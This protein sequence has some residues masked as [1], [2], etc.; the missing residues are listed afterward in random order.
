[1]RSDIGKIAI[2]L[3]SFE[4]KAKS[5]LNIAKYSE[6]GLI[7]NFEDDHHFLVPQLLDN[8]QIV[9]KILGNDYES[10]I[11]SYFELTPNSTFDD[12]KNSVLKEII[13]R[14][15]KIPSF[16]KL[17]DIMNWLDKKNYKV[18][19]FILRIDL[20]FNNNSLYKI[21]DFFRIYKISFIGFSHINLASRQFKQFKSICSALFQNIIYEKLYDYKDIEAF[22]N[23]LEEL[24]RIKLP[25]LLKKEIFK[26]CGGNLWLVKQ[27]VRYFRN[28]PNSGIHEVLSHNELLEKAALV[29]ER[30][31]PDEKRTAIKILNEEPLTDDE[32][33]N[34]EYL[35]KIG[36]FIEKDREY[37][38]AI[39]LLSKV[40]DIKP[41]TH[42]VNLRND[43]IYL[44]N[45]IISDELTQ[46]EEK[47]LK[48]FIENKN[49]VISRYHLGDRI[50]KNNEDAYSDWAL[51][52]LIFRLREKLYSL[53]LSK[54]IIKIR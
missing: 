42:F 34:F 13:H 26:T 35:I 19:L 11:L 37:T 8:I 40:V 24:F 1:M 17:E 33:V 46:Q 29:W 48:Y 4:S 39:P 21:Q 5:W 2:T 44:G 25:V 51:D 15:I 14:K 45:R 27:A 43:G 18:V 9:K 7:I 6:S 31:L 10:Y 47:I 41:K 22:F 28:N 23:Y 12:L 20:F 50:W 16:R 3:S 38:L 52:R 32:K 49:K 54:N 36:F 53:G 30:L